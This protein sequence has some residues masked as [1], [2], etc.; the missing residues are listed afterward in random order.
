MRDHLG[1]PGAAGA[2]FLSQ[3]Q[4]PHEFEKLCPGGVKD[5][6]SGKILAAPSVRQ[7][8]ALYGRKGGYKKD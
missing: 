2:L 1:T 3:C 7:I 4:F 5:G 6:N 8:R